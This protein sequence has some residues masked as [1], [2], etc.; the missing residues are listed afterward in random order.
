MT[1]ASK[2]N[3]QKT[4]HKKQKRNTYKKRK[5]QHKA[6]KKHHK[7]VKKGG[8][9]EFV[10]ACDL[11]GGS[12]PKITDAGASLH[13][14]IKSGIKQ[15]AA[16]NKIQIA[17]NKM[18]RGGS[19]KVIVPQPPAG[20]NGGVTAGQHTSG[21]N[22]KTSL[23]TS[24]KQTADSVYDKQA[25]SLN[26]DPPCNPFNGPCGTKGGSKNQKK[27]HKKMKKKHKKNKKKTSKLRKGGM[28][29]PRKFRMR[30]ERYIDYMIEKNRIKKARAKAKEL[31]SLP[32]AVATPV[33]Q[34][35]E[36]AALPFAPSISKGGN[37]KKR[38]KTKHA[39][40]KK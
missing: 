9:G 31:A 24:L 13:N 33:P 21:Q 26:I 7:M 3:K 20:S 16:Q 27:T 4:N 38:R 32:V 39:K 25:A 40:S 34:V 6:T 19:K 10:S 36:V 15:T 12:C 14:M 1:K 2:K 17:A 23:S 18:A 11:P 22:Y 30:G 35:A 37:K 5:P 8:A 28:R 29:S